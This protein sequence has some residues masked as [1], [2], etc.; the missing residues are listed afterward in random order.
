M[1]RWIFALVCLSVFITSAATLYS[2]HHTLE[3][4]RHAPSHAVRPSTAEPTFDPPPS[5]VSRPQPVGQALQPTS[6]PV[7]PAPTAS[8]TALPPLRVE[9]LG[10]VVE[11][12]PSKSSALIEDT[13]TGTRRTCQLGEVIQGRRLIAIE[14]GFITLA[15]EGVAERVD[16]EGGPVAD[17]L[18]DTSGDAVSNTDPWAPVVRQVFG[19]HQML[20]R[21]E[22]QT[23]KRAI[24]PVSETERSVNRRLV[25]DTLKTNPFR[26]LREAALAPA[27]EQ[28]RFVGVVLNGFPEDGV[29]RQSGFQ[30]GDIIQSVNGQPVTNPLQVLKLPAQLQQADIVV[31]TLMRHGRPLTLTYRMQ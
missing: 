22:A 31:V 10:T 26:I 15:G 28:G 24:T 4:L 25:W 13:T 5:R 27:Y 8:R 19:S 23:L 9:L 14:R 20:N 12:E 30:P 11:A 17:S 18:G 16:L 29:F 1:F 2:T 21:E 6:A 3:Q 7:S